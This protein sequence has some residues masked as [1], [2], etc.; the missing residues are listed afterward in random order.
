LPSG[1]G[2]GLRAGSPQ[3]G[4][5]CWK[6]KPS[7][8]EKA[9]IQDCRNPLR[10]FEDLIHAKKTTNRES[11]KLDLRLLEQAKKGETEK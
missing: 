10:R 5:W 4:I 6:R 9:V 3:P 1:K 11:D 2:W 7:E 8:G